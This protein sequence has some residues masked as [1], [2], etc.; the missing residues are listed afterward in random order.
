MV[1]PFAEVVSGIAVIIATMGGSAVVVKALGQWMQWKRFAGRS[2]LSRVEQPQRPFMTQTVKPP[3]S[4]WSPPYCVP[5]DEL[6]LM[7]E[8][9]NLPTVPAAAEPDDEMTV[10]SLT[11]AVQAL[12]RRNSQLEHEVRL[13]NNVIAEFTP[14]RGV[15]QLGRGGPV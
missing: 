8:P 6:G 5:C 3:E 7:F 2:E 1:I 4:R 14:G 15:M 11:L 13:L 9:G 10:Q 12:R